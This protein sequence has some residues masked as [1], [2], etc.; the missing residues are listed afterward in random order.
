ML[1]DQDFRRLE[2]YPVF[3]A[4]DRKFDGAVVIEINGDSMEPTYLSG[5]K[6]LISKVHFE[7]WPFVSGPV[8]VNYDGAVVF[9][10]IKKN[11]YK[12][13]TLTLYSDNPQG[14]NLEIEVKSII[15]IWKAERI[16]DSRAV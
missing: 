1:D 14:G 7:K 12:D 8:I 15:S 3:D 5:T 11:F 4:D 10:R 16:V 2:T 6:V 13:K 9:K